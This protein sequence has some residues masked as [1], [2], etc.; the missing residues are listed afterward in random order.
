MAV[1]KKISTKKTTL[2]RGVVAKKVVKNP[3]KKKP[4][5]KPV[6]KAAPV[7]AKQALSAHYS[8]LEGEIK[9]LFDLL[10][11]VGKKNT[12]VRNSLNYLEKEQKALS[13][14]IVQAKTFVN[15]LKKMGIK[16][17]QSFP[18]NAE[19]IFSQVKDEINRLS[20]R[21]VR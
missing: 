13:K 12:L 15:R 9:K 18:E 14:Q 8:T 10:N 5:R 19:E 16:I 11:T 17:L 21:L 4:A 1:K 3:I 2:G 6:K 20:K 7:V